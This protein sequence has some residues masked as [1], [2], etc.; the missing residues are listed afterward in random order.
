MGFAL[1]CHPAICTPTTTNWATILSESFCRRFVWPPDSEYFDLNH[2]RG[3]PTTS[4]RRASRSLGEQLQSS[5][6]SLPLD[7]YVAT[8]RTPTTST[9]TGISAAAASCTSASEMTPATTD[10]LA[11]FIASLDAVPQL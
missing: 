5:I 10:D 3:T 11:N 1:S 2:Y 4:H 8:P 9:A 7:S 6:T